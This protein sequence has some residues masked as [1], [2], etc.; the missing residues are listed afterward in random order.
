MKIKGCLLVRPPML[1]AKSS[2]NFQVPTKIGH[3]LAVLGVWGQ[4]FQKVSI[5]TQKCTCVHESTSF[6]SFCVEICRGV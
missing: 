6:E 2:E 3:I 1:N 5:F 4:A